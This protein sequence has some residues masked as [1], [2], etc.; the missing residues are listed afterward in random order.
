MLTAIFTIIQTVVVIVTLVYAAI[1]IR[2]AT[3]DRHLTVYLKLN[4]L[5][6]NET[7]RSNRYHIFNHLPK[8]PGQLTRKDYEI[9][10]DTW[11]LMNQLGTI[12]HFDLASRKL[13]LELYSLQTVR[14]WTILE[15]HIRYYQ[16]DRGPFVRYFEEFAKLSKDYRKK[17]FREEHVRFFKGSREKPVIEQ[18][19]LLEELLLAEEHNSSST[20]RTAG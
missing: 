11:N 2:S 15:P 8:E 3:K 1:Q 18:D 17:R 16:A 19:F 20:S 14:L 9:A 7:T 12:A 10:R 13:L 5:F 4:E 6:D